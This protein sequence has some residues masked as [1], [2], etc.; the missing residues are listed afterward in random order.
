MNAIYLLFLI[1][2][3]P[4]LLWRRTRHGKNRR[5]WPQ[6]LFG[7]IDC[8]ADFSDRRHRDTNAPNSSRRIWLHAVSVGEVILLEPILKE[9]QTRI[10]DARIAI[11]TTTETGYDLAQQRFGDCFVFFAPF[12]FTWAIRNVL[13]RL[14]PDMLVLAEL[15]I[16]PNLIRVVADSGV[17]VAVVNGRLSEKSFQGYQRLGVIL[18][19]VM[20][21]ISMVGAQN[22][23]YAQRFVAIGC[24]PANVTVTGSVKF[25]GL[26][27][28]RRNSKTVELR[29]LAGLTD[30]NLT[31]VA[32]STQL[33]EDLIAAEAF[34][35]LAGDHPE[36]R[37]ILVPRHPGRVDQLMIKLKQLGVPAVRRSSLEQSLE[38]TSAVLVVDVIGELGFWWGCADVAYV[39]GSMGKRGGQNMLEPA[40]FG[41]PVSFGPSTENF[42]EIV[43]QFMES[44]AAIVIRNRE[45]LQAFVGHAVQDA[46]WRAE[47]G[48]RA[49]N[50]V[51]SH[52]GGSV[53]T[54]DAL[55]RVLDQS[56]GPK[57]KQVDL[58]KVA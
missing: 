31:F 35:S 39:G 6:K 27:T 26:E 33:E 37:M 7:L 51:M 19:P 28:D 56:N 2:A 55:C 3:S 16:W 17:P 52:V 53:R 9:L 44:D 5:G 40:A 30:A 32:G 12:D 8:P 25:D 20:S 10:P 38:G 18:R 23:V 14:R 48:S 34:Q 43:D 11:S 49:K 54:A 50:V 13:K 15:E 21:R 46:Q 58:G 29:Q 41:I 42:R 47:L 57:G 1:L 45:D 24:E 4:W 22:E 36:L